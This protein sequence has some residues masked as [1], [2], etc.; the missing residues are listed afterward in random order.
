VFSDEKLKKIL[1]LK[2]I[3]LEDTARDTL[4]DFKTHGWL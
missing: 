1:G 4:L 2:P 3:P